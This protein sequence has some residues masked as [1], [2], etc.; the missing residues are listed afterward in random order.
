MSLFLRIAVAF[1]ALV[2]ALQ[3]QEAAPRIAV[4]YVT[5]VPGNFSFTTQWSYN[6]NVFRNRYGQLVCDGLCP[7]RLLQL[8][9]ST[10]RILPDS[11]Q[12][13][14][15]LFDTAHYYHTLSAKSSC[16]E[17][18]GADFAYA[19]KQPDGSVLCHTTGSIATHCTL[20][21]ILTADSCV[22]YARLSSIIAGED[23]SY[24]CT[25]GNISIDK[26]LWKLGV[27]KGTFRFEFTDTASGREVIYWEGLV[28]CTVETG[29]H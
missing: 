12:L 22:A 28:N 7:E 18:A 26:E 15:S 4:N 20:S 9:D 27:L 1:I 3:A 21:F 23:Q 5:T 16:S 2:P 29:N 10:G 14:Y 11:V 19:Q 8:T 25:G 13:Y 17:F 6:E 24:S